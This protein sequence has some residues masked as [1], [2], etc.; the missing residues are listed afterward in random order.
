MLLNCLS[1]FQTVLRISYEISWYDGVFA[2]VESILVHLFSFGP[3]TAKSSCGSLVWLLVAVGFP[4]RVKSIAWNRDGFFLCQR[5][6]TTVLFVS[7]S[8]VHLS[9][10]R[11]TRSLSNAQNKTFLKIF[12]IPVKG[13]KPTNEYN[14]STLLRLRKISDKK[15]TQSHLVVHMHWVRMILYEPPFIHRSMLWIVLCCTCP[16]HFSETR[17]IL[18]ARNWDK[19]MPLPT[20]IISFPHF[21]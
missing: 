4:R 15:V 7:R 8:V 21:I 18:Q 20:S 5:G 17:H 14:P 2:I 3:C 12:P 13:W 10:W 11:M 19:T 6:I 1:L 9:F 16:D